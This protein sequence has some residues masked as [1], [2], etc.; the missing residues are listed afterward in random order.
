MKKLQRTSTDDGIEID[1]ND[2]Q[3]ENACLST[4]VRCDPASKMT[5]SREMQSAKDD[6]PRI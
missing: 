1:F 4:Q 6:L 2:E 5:S 3:F